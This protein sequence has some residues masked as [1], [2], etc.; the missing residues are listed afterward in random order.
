MGWTGGISATLASLAASELGRWV[1]F[2]QS[3]LPE[4]RELCRRWSP[5]LFVWHGACSWRT[6]PALARLVRPG[7]TRGVVIEHHY[8]AGFERAKVP[9]PWRFRAM[10][11]L[12]Y[13]LMK[14]VVAVSEGQAAWIRSAGLTGESSLRVIR[15]SRQLEPFLDLPEPQPHGGPLRLVAYGRLSEQKGFDSLIRAVKELPVGSVSL[16]IA[17]EGALGSDLR[18]LAA[19]DPR[20]RF[21]GRI[22][23][24]PKLLADCDAVVVPSRWEPWGNVALEARAA[25]R[26]LV[27][28]DVDGLSEQVRGCGLAVPADD[29]QALAAALRQL[30]ALPLAERRALGLQGR[31]T[32]RTAWADY[33]D[34]WEKLLR[35]FS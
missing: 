1:E 6:L 7:G 12:H 8:S 20:I 27:V 21:L 5:D 2:R 19:E 35:E 15:S 26:P 28:S 25:A 3:A 23:A 22:D 4:A 34:G 18:A 13:G 11:R 32:A 33:I 10:L 29:A 9:S 31:A 30:L 17:G 14:R 16:S 24:V